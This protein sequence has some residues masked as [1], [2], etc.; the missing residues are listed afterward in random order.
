MQYEIIGRSK[1]MREYVEALMPSLIKQLGLERTRKFLLIDISRDA[2]PKSVLGLTQVL[3]GLDSCVIALR[4]QHW[5]KLGATLAHEM[6]HVKQFVKGQ[7]KTYN[8]A[9]FWR[10]R[11]VKD[12]VDYLDR[13]WEREAF[14]KQELLFRRA[15]TEE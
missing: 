6:V 11:R 2:A 3:P 14:M 4:P 15:A 7:V 5:E 8:G 9:T 13:P 10:G 1:K 12:T